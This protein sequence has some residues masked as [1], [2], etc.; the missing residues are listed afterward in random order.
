V[1]RTFL[2]TDIRPLINTATPAAR[3]AA[4]NAAARHLCGRLRHDTAS[5][6]AC[7]PGQR[8]AWAACQT[9]NALRAGFELTSAV[10]QAIAGSY[11]QVMGFDPATAIST[12]G[13]HRDIVVPALQHAR[14]TR[15]H[16]TLLALARHAAATVTDAD[17]GSTLARQ[18]GHGGIPDDLWDIATSVT[19]AI[20]L[21]RH[22]A[23]TEA[24]QLLCT[25]WDSL[26]PDPGTAPVL[27]PFAPSPN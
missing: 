5:F 3:H 10:T 17:Q 24:A 23:L 2:D 27:L 13:Y 11:L 6:P 9:G 22:A 14:P 4:V 12:A 25:L 8:P 18:A 7:G 1:Y 15:H 19:T 20:T 21:Y 16:A 26:A